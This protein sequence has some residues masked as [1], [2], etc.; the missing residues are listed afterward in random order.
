MHFEFLLLLLFLPLEYPTSHSHKQLWLVMVFLGSQLL[1]PSP[2]CHIGSYTFW[3]SL[4]KLGLNPGRIGNAKFSSWVA[5]RPV[6]DYRG[7]EWIEKGK[8]QWRG[9][10]RIKLR[11]CFYFLSQNSFQSSLTQLLLYRFLDSHYHKW[12]DSP[13]GVLISQISLALFHGL[14]PLNDLVSLWVMATIICFS[15]VGFCLQTVSGIYFQD[16]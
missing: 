16:L 3:Y 11:G 2:L 12:N 4:P 15:S 10:E 8:I 9:R 14:F 7:H 1:G 6:G 5:L 13:W